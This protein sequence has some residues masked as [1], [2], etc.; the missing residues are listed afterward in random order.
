MKVLYAALWQKFVILLP[1]L[2]T[3]R[4][5]SLCP[6]GCR[7]Y[8]GF[9]ATSLT[10][11]C[12]RNVNVS[13]EQLSQQLDSLLSSNLTYGHLSSLTLANSPL[14]NVPRSVCRLTTL[15]QLNL[16]HNQ[17]TRLPDNCFS[18]L[19]ALTVFS[20][21]DNS[22]TELHDGLFDGLRKLQTLKLGH[23]HISSIG[24][25]LFNKS[26]NLISLETVGLKYNRIQTL[27][28]WPMYLGLN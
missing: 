17:L 11:D 21:S 3:A 12:Q 16:D 19:T 23:N 7:C 9:P 10:V 13:A 14:T 28:P 25:R 6:N 1:V 24:L 27:E 5:T 8:G 20:A 18:N 4:T 2:A 15:T 26:A 22:I